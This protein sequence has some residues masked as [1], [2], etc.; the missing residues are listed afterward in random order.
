[1]FVFWFSLL[2]RYWIYKNIASLWRNYFFFPLTFISWRLITLQYCNDFRQ[3]STWASHGSTCAPH[4]EPPSH[5]TPPSH[6]SGSSQCTNPEHPSL[7]SN[8]GRPTLESIPFSALLSQN[9][10]PSPSPTGS[11]SLY[12]TSASLFRFAYRVIVTTFLNS[13]LKKFLMREN[14]EVNW[15][16][17]PMRKRHLSQELI[18][19]VYNLVD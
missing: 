1:M 6:P 13:I 10:P 17:V 15:D 11:Q 19:S 8:L 2:K 14:I 7:A 18:V 5:I 4:P 9:I 3:T 16:L 12:Y